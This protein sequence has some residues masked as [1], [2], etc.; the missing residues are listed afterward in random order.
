MKIIDLECRGCGQTMRPEKREGVKVTKLESGG[1]M[2]TQNDE[3]FLFTC[4]YCGKSFATWNQG[5]E[6]KKFASQNVGVYIGGNATGNI[7]I[8][9]NN[10]I[11]I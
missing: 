2:Y 9:N 3:P 8:G 7:I 5:V 4:H 6:T 1:I 11:D 10:N